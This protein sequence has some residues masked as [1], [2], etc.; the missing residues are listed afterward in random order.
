MVKPE[1]AEMAD[2]DDEQC[3]PWIESCILR[4]RK[5][6]KINSRERNVSGVKRNEDELEDNVREAKELAYLS[7]K[8]AEL[9]HKL[10]E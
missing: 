10:V 3:R 8:Q 5:E 7:Q 4:K 1:E 6:D 9:L 2:G